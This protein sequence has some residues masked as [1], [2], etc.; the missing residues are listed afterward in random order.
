MII[1]GTFML[2]RVKASETQKSRELLKMY[3]NSVNEL[4]VQMYDGPAEY[5]N[6]FDEWNMLTY[7]PYDIQG[8]ILNDAGQPI[9]PNEF[10]PLRV[11]NNTVVAAIAGE[12]GF[13]AGERAPDLNGAEKE[14]LYYAI[15]VMKGDTRYIVFTR[16]SA[17][18]MNENLSQLTLTIV[19]MVIIA[20]L[21]T[22][23]LW[24][25]FASTLTGPIIALTRRAKEMAAGDLENE[26][27]VQSKDEI[28]QLTESFNH[29]AKELNNTVST[30]ASEKNKSEAILHN[31][32]DG[33][34]A[35]DATGYVMHANSASSELLQFD[36]LQTLHVWDMLARL[37]FNTDEARRLS[38]ENV[39][40]S[41]TNIG[42][43]YVYA[44]VTPYMNKS[45]QVDGF[46]IVLQDVTKHTKLDI[47]RKEFV[48]NVS[49]E[50]RTPLTSVQTYTETLLNGAIEETE[51]ARTF[52][53]VID[54]AARQMALL[55]K[56]LLELSNLDNKQLTMEKEV[57]DLAG[58][59]RLA[60]RQ[61]QV[62][63]DK[64]NQR[65]NFDAPD[66]LM[67]I[68]A[69]AARINQVFSNILTNSI[70]YSPE[71]TDVDVSMEVTDRFYR[72]FIKDYG[73][74]IPPED[75]RH[76]FERFYRV[77]KARSRAMGG[78]GLGLAI[79]KEIM[80]EHDGRILVSSELGQG[81]VMVL[82]FLKYKEPAYA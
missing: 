19:M 20:L 34:L 70:K 16:M 18:T 3:A 49:H 79:A 27:A 14:W 29:M 7:G 54:N 73:I 61:N 59:L 51:N 39:L 72:V 40:E 11:N 26:I 77:D 50:L 31:M 78:T 55:V 69:D 37:G 35:Y 57:V 56:D 66:K 62:L 60:V 1:S 10:R 38:P 12:E 68:E 5:I 4:I 21:L 48:A 81:T 80:E 67:F 30:M 17:T 6:A 22:C 45:N 64:K 32:T 33:V 52:L 58:L 9:A 53:K 63:A 75:V 41:T 71:N 25:L 43:R 15:P 47:M 44:C 46:V 42:G 28:G 74:G 24:F 2:L 13:S 82:R 23:T 76:I 8:C 36:D 65:I